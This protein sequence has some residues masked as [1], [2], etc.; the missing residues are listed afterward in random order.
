MANSVAERPSA[1]IASTSTI[2]D[3]SAY[4]AALASPEV[5]FLAG[6]SLTAPAASPWLSQDRE[7]NHLE[8]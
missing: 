6:S 7:G 2:M 1:S 4:L 5:A 8:A 3:S